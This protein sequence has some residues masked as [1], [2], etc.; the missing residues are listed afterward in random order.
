MSAAVAVEW[1]LA[2]TEEHDL[3]DV[4]TWVVQ[5]KV[6]KPLTSRRHCRFTSL[7]ELRNARAPLLLDALLEELELVFKLIILFLGVRF[8]LL[9]LLKFLLPLD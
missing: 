5:Q 3:W 1:L 4:P 6:I 9:L 2:F 7:P 8:L